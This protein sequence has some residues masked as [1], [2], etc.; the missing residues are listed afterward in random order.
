MPAL[1]PFDPMCIGK[2]WHHPP[3]EA[4]PELRAVEQESLQGIEELEGML[5]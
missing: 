5:R 4:L 1:I 3:Q 2:P